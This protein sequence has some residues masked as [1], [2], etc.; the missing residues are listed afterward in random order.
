MSELKHM[1]DLQ[2]ENQDL[3]FDNKDLKASCEE[4][5]EKIEDL[6]SRLKSIL[7]LLECMHDNR[8]VTMEWEDNQ[9]ALHGRLMV[10]KTYPAALRVYKQPSPGTH[11]TR[12]STVLDIKNYYLYQVAIDS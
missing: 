4:Q 3:D 7:N 1:I 10:C 5:Q 12:F 2:N 8:L 9:K 6:K 11:T